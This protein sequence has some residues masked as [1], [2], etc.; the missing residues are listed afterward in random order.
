MTI[1]TGKERNDFVGCVCLTIQRK[2]VNSRDQPK[3]LVDTREGAQEPLATLELTE[4]VLGTASAGRQHDR[5]RREWRT[6]R[7]PQLDASD[8]S[9][10][11]LAL[12]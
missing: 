1:P 12:G 8:K 3:L 2:E 4:P 5:G 7:S 10:G 6:I 11:R 9:D